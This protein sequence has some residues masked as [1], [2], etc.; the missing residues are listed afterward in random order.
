MDEEACNFNPNATI[1]NSCIFFTL[2]ELNDTNLCSSSTMKIFINNNYE[3]YLWSTGDTTNSIQISQ[4]GTYYVTVT[5]NSDVNHPTHSTLIIQLYHM[6]I[7]VM[8]LNNTQ[9]QVLK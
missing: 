5:N 6:L 3:N 1:D 2:D 4:A 8:Y 7:L 9:T